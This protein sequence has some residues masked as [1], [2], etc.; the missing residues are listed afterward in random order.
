MVIRP[1]DHR[2]PLLEMAVV[3]RSLLS[4]TAA[5]GKPTITITAFPLPPLTSISTSRAST[6]KTVAEKTFANMLPRL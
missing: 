3:T 5:S 1:R 6:P 2:K 4:F